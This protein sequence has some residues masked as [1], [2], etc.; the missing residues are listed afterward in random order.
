MS[1][2]PASCDSITIDEEFRAH[3]PP[4]TDSERQMLRQDIER[5]G[6]LSPLIIWN[7]EGKV[8]LVDGTTDTRFC[9]N[10]KG[11]TNSRQPSWFSARAKMP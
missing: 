4:L 8:I 2:L 11:W 1:I 10:S 5:S 6:L 3:C 9:G 7:H